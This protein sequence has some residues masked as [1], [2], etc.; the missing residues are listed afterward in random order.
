MLDQ[1]SKSTSFEEFRAQLLTALKKHD[2]AFLEDI[3][4]PDVGLAIGGGKG[5]RAFLQEWQELADNSPVWTRL[6]R[7]VSHGAQF[8]AESNEFHSP[9]VSFDDS[10]S[11]LP[12]GI[13]WNKNGALYKEPNE[14]VA[15]LKNLFRE[16]LT[17]VEPAQCQPVFAEWVKVKTT[18][19]AQGYMKS[20]DVYS[21]YDEFA[22]FKKNQNKWLLTWFGF[23]SL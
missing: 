11:E 21:A 18:K 7:V 22:V 2:K 14:G 1:A 17:I 9:A 12:Q 19:G 13:V 4:S 20:S 6:E 8:D 15:P 16:Q 23:A 5:K 3:L 10:H